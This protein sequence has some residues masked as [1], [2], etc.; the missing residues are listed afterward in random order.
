VIAAS[1]PLWL[2]TFRLWA[3]VTAA[4]ARSTACA[5]CSKKPETWRYASP[6]GRARQH[7]YQQ[8]YAKHAFPRQLF[9]CL[10]RG[11]LGKHICFRYT[12]A[13]KKAFFVPVLAT[14]QRPAHGRSTPSRQGG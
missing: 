4:N 14:L 6:G 9:L 11:C 2:M 13:P 5:Q 10:S 3:S 1:K 8:P 12:M 7:L